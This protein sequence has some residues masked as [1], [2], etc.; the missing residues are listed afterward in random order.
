[1]AR[2]NFSDTV[3]LAENDA[4]AK[5][6]YRPLSNIQVTVYLG[7]TTTV[8]TI[9][10][11]RTGATPK[12]NPFTTAAGGGVDFWA[13]YGEF[14][15]KFHDLNVPARIGDKTIGWSSISGANA[16]IPSAK[17]AADGGM[18]LA[19]LD[20]VAI[21]QFDPIGTV[22]QW[23]RPTNAVAVPNG[24]AIC[25]GATI[26]SGSHDFGTGSSIVLPDLRNAFV[27]GASTAVGDGGASN[28]ETAANAPGIRGTGGSHTKNIAHTHNIAAHTHTTTSAGAHQHAVLANGTTATTPTGQ[29]L[30]AAAGGIFVAGSAHT[31]GVIVSGATDSLGAHT[32]PVSS[33]A[34]TSD[35]GGSATLDGRP[36]YVGLL[37]LMKIKRN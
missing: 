22:I 21:R 26:A 2:D 35:A 28:G 33:T 27:L 29:W 3:G 17:L 37:F 14:D 19:A 36:R 1:M 4:Q 20:A 9:Y 13:E 31:H 30:G 8:A 7:G 16:A 32:H 34:M 18:P 11:G 5:P 25:D 6:V 12:S 24:W 10:Q 15:V 23:W